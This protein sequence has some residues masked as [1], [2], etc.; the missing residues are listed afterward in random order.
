MCFACWL[1]SR[2]AS[3]ASFDNSV[4]WSDVDINRDVPVRRHAEQAGV[5]QNVVQL[6]VLVASFRSLEQKKHLLRQA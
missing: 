6:A 5:Q 1:A 4:V 2:V 3:D